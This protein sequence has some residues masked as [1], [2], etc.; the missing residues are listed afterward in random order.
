MNFDDP[1]A[2]LFDFRMKVTPISSLLSRAD[3][4]V[5]PVAF[6]KSQS[7]ACSEVRMTIKGPV[8][9]G[10][11][12]GYTEAKHRGPGFFLNFPL[13]KTSGVNPDEQMVFAATIETQ[14][15][16][17]LPTQTSPELQ[18][19]LSEADRIVNGIIYQ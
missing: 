8:W 5:S 10:A 19:R 16:D 17:T 4:Y 6:K 12:F 18:R 11:Y 14:K 1:P 3:L 13:T 7:G 2:C 9:A 15:P